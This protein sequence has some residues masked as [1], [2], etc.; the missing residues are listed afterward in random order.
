MKF[1]HPLSELR[2]A[3]GRNKG[4]FKTQPAF[5]K[6]FG[7]SGSLIQKIELDDRDID[8]ELCCDI[9][10][11]FGLIPESLKRKRGMPVSVIP[12]G[13]KESNPRE[14]LRQRIITWQRLFRLP[15]MSKDEAMMKLG[16]FLDA[17]IKQQKYLTVLA[18][19]DHWLEDQIEK[20]NLRVPMKQVAPADFRWKTFNVTLRKIGN[21]ISLVPRPA[22]SR[23][24]TRATRRPSRNQSARSRT[25]ARPRRR[26]KAG[27]NV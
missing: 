13:P 26:Y 4:D 20:F 17:A 8:D 5:A 2:K 9:A 21:E 7:V 22:R 11:K 19:L 18:R 12:A 10:L 16:V 24:L 25:S 3:L 1:K 23:S 6:Q 15:I 27:G 14:R